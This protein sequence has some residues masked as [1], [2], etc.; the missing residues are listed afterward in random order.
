MRLGILGGGRAAWAWGTAWLRIGWPLSGVWLRPESE[1]RLPELLG[2]RRRDV[3]QLAAEAELLLV[4]VSDRAVDGIVAKI[5]SGEAI[6]FHS[7][8]AL[9]APAGGF[10]LHPLKALPPVGEPSDLADTLLVFQGEHPKTARLITT[11]VGARFAEVTAEQKPLYHAAA[12]FGANY[13]AAVLDVSADLMR[14]AGAGDVRRDLVALAESAI[15]N[16]KAHDDARRFTGPA[17]RGD[18]EVMARHVSA[19]GDDAQVAELYKLL[20]AWITSARLAT[21]K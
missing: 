2:A 8:G 17:A 4:A 20:A 19:I 18:E 10:S 13:V 12:V 14:R 7:S 11:A 16:W 9:A 3:D 15:Q 21:P 1:S 5:P 6:I